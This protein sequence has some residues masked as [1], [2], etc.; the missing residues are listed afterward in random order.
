MPF[1]AA[2]GKDR[3]RSDYALCGPAVENGIWEGMAVEDRRV[4]CLDCPLRFTRE[5]SCN[6]DFLSVSSLDEFARTFEEAILD[7]AKRGSSWDWFPSS[8]YEVESAYQRL[9]M[10]I[11]SP[12]KVVEGFLSSCLDLPQDDDFWRDWN[13]T[14]VEQYAAKP[15]RQ[16]HAGLKKALKNLVGPNTFKGDR[17]LHLYALSALFEDVDSITSTHFLGVFGRLTEACR[18]AV[19]ANASLEVT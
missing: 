6:T 17:L 18:K 2:L 7:I 11:P 5:A 15:V 1:T 3:A 12:I 10:Q 14:Y 16:A 19:Q 8:I 4:Y 13:Y 9:G